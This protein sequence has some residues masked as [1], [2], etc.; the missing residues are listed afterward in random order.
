MSY[1][2]DDE[3]VY[4]GELLCVDAEDGH[5]EHG[6]H[7]GTVLEVTDDASGDQVVTVEF[8]CGPTQD[9]LGSELRPA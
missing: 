5:L 9:I 6:G 1:K 7:G 3:I 8:D 4:D 2:A